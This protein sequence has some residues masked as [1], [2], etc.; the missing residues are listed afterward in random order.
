MP[1]L[2]TPYATISFP[3][4]FQPRPRA[5]GGEA[6][7][8]ASLIFSPEQQKS[9]AFK[10]LK[11]AAIDVAYKEWGDKLQL[12]TVKMPFR[13]GAEKAGQWAGYNDGDIFISPWTK[14]KPGVVDVQREDIHTPEEVWA[15]QLVRANVTPFA[16]VNS[17]K[18]GV[19]FALNHIQVIKTDTARIDG[20]GNARDAFDDGEVDEED[21]GSPF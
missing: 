2:N 1:S 18:K 7:F 6:V 17:G 4:L 20:R 3:H 14:S 21:G 8:S 11:Q 19:S 15:G 12:K 10:A 5:E 9:P 16:W 13:D